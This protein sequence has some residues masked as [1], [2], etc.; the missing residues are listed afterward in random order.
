[1]KYISSLDTVHL[2]FTC[3]FNVSAS[4]DFV[5]TC[6][7]SNLGQALLFQFNLPL[8]KHF[9]DNYRYSGSKCCLKF[10]KKAAS[11]TASAFLFKQQFSTFMSRYFLYIDQH[12][13]QRPRDASPSSSLHTSFVNGRHLLVECPGSFSKIYTS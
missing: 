2:K 8:L 3:R 5:L 13:K 7:K 10:K 4:V 12:A 9:V 11:P 1:M 6:K